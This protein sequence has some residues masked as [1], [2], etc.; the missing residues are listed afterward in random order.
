MAPFPSL[1]QDVAR[2]GF[3]IPGVLADVKF[4]YEGNFVLLMYQGSFHIWEMLLL[5]TFLV[6][7]WLLF[8][9]LSVGGS[10]SHPG[11]LIA[12]FLRMFFL[13]WAISVNQT[14]I[15]MFNK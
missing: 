6:F 13:R 1:V 2:V 9:F 12:R 3:G 5:F 14:R 11:V 15:T 8:H 4:I 10:S 7:D